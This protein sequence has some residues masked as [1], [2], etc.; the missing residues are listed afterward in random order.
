MAKARN[1][2]KR[3]IAKKDKAQEKQFIMWAVIITV[4]LLVI[5]YWAFI[6]NS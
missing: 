1:Q 6:S 5:T 2:R 4:A 3:K